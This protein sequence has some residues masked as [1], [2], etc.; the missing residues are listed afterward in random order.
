MKKLMGVFRLALTVIIV[1]IVLL[2]Y[3]TAYRPLKL[4][5]ER[6][7]LN[8]FVLMVEATDKTAEQFILRSVEGAAGISSRSAIRQLLSDYFDGN[9]TLD[10]VKSYT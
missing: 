5:L 10:Q 9:A 3:F 6:Q 7:M 4:E 8:Q 2:S 1:F